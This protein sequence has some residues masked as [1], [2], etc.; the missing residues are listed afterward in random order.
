MGITMI[1]RAI[2]QKILDLTAQ[3]PVVTVLGPRQSGKTTLVKS[4]FPDFSYANLEDPRT[5]E[6]AQ[7]DYEGFF[8][9]YKEPLIIDEVQRVPELLSAI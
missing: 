5:R 7:E 6:L 1:E 3:V 2:K 4:L 8:A 9:K